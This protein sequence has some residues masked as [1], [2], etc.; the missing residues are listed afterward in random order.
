MKHG[1]ACGALL[2]LVGF[3][4]YVVA[5]ICDTSAT[6]ARS[7][8]RAFAERDEQL[9]RWQERTRN[10]VV[11]WPRCATIAV[12][13]NRRPHAILRGV[14]DVDGRRVAEPAGVLRCSG[15]VDVDRRAFD[16]GCAHLH[17]THERVFR[18][19]LRVRR[20]RVLPAGCAHDERGHET[21]KGN[22]GRE[23][24]LTRGWRR[25]LGVREWPGGSTRARV[26]GLTPPSP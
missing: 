19:E 21:V 8:A 4:R 7:F 18:E 12:D 5:V 3:Q 17:G 9:G 15:H 16:R 14:R 2:H 26:E 23:G 22:P 10:F 6:Q 13:T 20:A 11:R 24:I 25:S 1:R